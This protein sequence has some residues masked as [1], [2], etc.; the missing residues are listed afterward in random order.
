MPNQPTPV[1]ISD[2]ALAEVEKRANAATD[3][4]WTLYTGGAITAGQE[5]HCVAKVEFPRLPESMVDGRFIAHARTDIPALCQTVRAL[6]QLVEIQ[7]RES[8]GD[9]TTVGKVLAENTALREQL[10]QVTKERNDLLD[11]MNVG[12][13]EE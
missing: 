3:G 5:R 9:L 8:D 6:K 7:S 13:P 2:E 10:A 4:P 1:I 12:R 11:A